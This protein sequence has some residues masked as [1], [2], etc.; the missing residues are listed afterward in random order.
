MVANYRAKFAVV[1]GASNGLGRYFAFELAKRGINLLLVSLPHSGIEK[2]VGDCKKLY[3]VE[4]FAFE[5]DLREKQSVIELAKLINQDY[6]LIALINN[7][8]MGGTSSFVDCDIEYIDSIIQLNV[9]AT[10][11]LTH[12][13]LSNMIE[14]GEGYILNVSSMASF[15]PMGYKT[16]YPASKKFIESFTLGLN[17]ELKGSG[18]SVSVV[19]PGPMKTNRSITLRIEKQGRLGRLSLQCPEK[20]AKDSIDM[21]FKRKS[22]MVL[23]IHNKFNRFVLQI[24]PGWIRLPVITN[25]VKR[26]L[27]SEKVKK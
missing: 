7:A 10:S 12:Q 5:V 27:I 6:K 26:E 19:H 21:M 20:V 15:S 18:V 4:C 2:V 14:Q 22:Q 1:T 16:V 8:G 23:G 11:L 9:A 17:Q 25:A 13:L 24:V 3:S